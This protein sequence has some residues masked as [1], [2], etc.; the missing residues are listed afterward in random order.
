MKKRTFRTPK[1]PRK[2]MDEYFFAE[3]HKLRTFEN[4]ALFP[5][6]AK[7][8]PARPAGA[9]VKAPVARCACWI[10][11]MS[12]LIRIR[13]LNNCSF[14]FSFSA[15]SVFVRETMRATCT[16]QVFAG[17]PSAA[18]ANS[19]CSSTGID[20]TSHLWMT[21][22][23]S[24]ATISNCAASSMSATAQERVAS[25]PPGTVTCAS[26][27]RKVNVASPEVPWTATLS[28]SCVFSSSA[29][30]R[31]ARISSATFVCSVSTRDSSKPSF[32]S[33]VA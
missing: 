32:R 14:C 2:R 18:A 21:S 15:S 16:R 23:S 13:S 25:E 26:P 22:P 11:P 7:E 19:T 27:I 20:D 8:F 9:L 1:R 30:F 12:R 3:F 24:P 17:T 29:L 10:S 28:L 33:V 6:A 4:R 5:A 31:R